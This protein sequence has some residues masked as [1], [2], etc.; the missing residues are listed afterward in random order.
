M[1][2]NRLYELR[3]KN[4]LSQEQMAEIF[5]VS[6]Q[7]VQKWESGAN[8]PELGKL[9]AI[10]KYFHVSLDMLLCNED[11]RTI[12]E[13]RLNKELTPNY[14]SIH[15]WESYSSDLMI[16]YTQ[17]VEE[18]KDIEKLH[19][20]FE[21]VSNLPSAKE[22]EQLAD[23]IFNM[24]FNTPLRDNYAF[25]E[26]STLDE[27]KIL[28]PDWDLN[29]PN[30][31]SKEVLQ[32]KIRGAWI[33]RICGCLLGKPIEGIR[34]NELIPLLKETKNYPMF[35]YILQAELSEEM[36]SR[37][38]FNLRNKCYA[39]AISCAPVD[40]DTNYTVM[41]AYIIER[42][43]KNFKPCDVTKMW[44][45][46]QPKD[47]YCT[48]ERVA[49]KNFVNGYLPPDSA[50][51]KNPYR[52]WIGAQI[53]ADYYGYINPGNPEIAAEM[54]W[55]DACISHVKNGIYGEMF[56]AAILA[57]AAVSKDI[58][59][60]IQCGLSQIPKTSRLFDEIIKLM[61]D[62]EN[63]VSCKECFTKI[64]E[65]F[66]ESRE[67]DWCHT[68]SNAE[69]VVAALLYGNLKYGKS[70]CLAV[71]AGFDTDCNGATVGSIIGM[72]NGIDDIPDEWYT[73][74]H[75]TLDTSIFGVG[76]IKIQDMVDLTIK[77]IGII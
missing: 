45:E 65:R 7:A 28:R 51:Y 62:Y 57:G 73:P 16:E 39:D 50:K 25:Y 4:D 26:P 74:I 43:G 23:V 64:H 19:P 49:F 44:L 46:K 35:R 17:C 2:Q 54:A 3:K 66:D 37:Y 29:L 8:L 75:D 5:G 6:R 13:L 18:G 68:I 22:K 24:A 14:E 58:K 10:G 9:M 21:A 33:G 42:F 27:I 32:N 72:I 67:H 63:G 59:Q 38:Q 55:C 36:Y 52:E 30:L 20:L 11:N 77:H 31:P 12:E 60:I 56:I 41:A 1:I 53:R 15:S 69:I 71:E 47:A 40:D 48:A 61:D 70:I 34:T 76:K